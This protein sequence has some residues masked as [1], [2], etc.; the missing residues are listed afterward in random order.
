MTGL[1]A[2]MAETLSKTAYGP[3]LA[4]VDEL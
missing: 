4:T 2:K 1:A 3:L